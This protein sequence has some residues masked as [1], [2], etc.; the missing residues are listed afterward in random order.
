[1]QVRKYNFGKDHEL[2]LHLWLDDSDTDI[3]Y[4]V[5]S[6]SLPEDVLKFL[7][8]SVYFSNISKVKLDYVLSGFIIGLELFVF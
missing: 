4:G 7:V 8:I 3:S 2:L 5:G 6:T 1:M